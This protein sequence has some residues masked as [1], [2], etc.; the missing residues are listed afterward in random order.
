M[1]LYGSQKLLLRYARPQV[2]EA[3][4]RINGK[5][6]PVRASRGWTGTSISRPA[7]VILT[8][9]GTTGEF[10]LNRH[11]LGKLATASRYVEDDPVVEHP[12]GSIRVIKDKR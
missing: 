7:K 2:Q 5:L 8:L 3:I 12:H 10:S 9:Q 11:R 4:Q 1:S 6:I